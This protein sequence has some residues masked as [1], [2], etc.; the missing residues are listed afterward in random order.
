MKQ[1]FKELLVLLLVTPICIVIIIFAMQKA[2]QSREV[3]NLTAVIEK[4]ELV[5][6]SPVFGSI[7]HFPFEEGD[8]VKA[9]ST[10]A[11]IN[12][13]DQKESPELQSDVYVYNKL[14]GTITIKSPVD[15]VVAKKELAEKSTIKPEANLIILH[16]LSN[17]LIKIQ[18]KDE[19][20]TKTF[21]STMLT[22]KQSSFNFPIVFSKKLPVSDKA[23]M[24]YY[25]AN[26]VD[27]SKADLFY[28]NQHVIV[29]VK[30]KSNALT[31][32]LDNLFSR[33]GSLDA[34]KDLPFN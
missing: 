12:I 34:I 13:I 3:V 33:I 1:V 29:K 27:Q 23:G 31:G 8:V 4:K 17:T 6:S 14:N 11:V 10:I 18:T 25:Y 24:I 7:E 21:E 30:K 28:E 32:K 15:A 22:N 20:P 9:N 16:P 2:E 26:F 5:I 19:L